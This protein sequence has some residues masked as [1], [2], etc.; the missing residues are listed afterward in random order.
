MSKKRMSYGDWMM[1]IRNIHY[2]NPRE[3]DKGYEKINK[4]LL[5]QNKQCT[6]ANPKS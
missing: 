1:Y 3:M 4:G 5:I 6:L 2:A